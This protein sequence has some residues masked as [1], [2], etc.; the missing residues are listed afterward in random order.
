MSAPPAE[1]GWDSL[2]VTALDQTLFDPTP[3]DQAYEVDDA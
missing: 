1:R 3:V 2:S